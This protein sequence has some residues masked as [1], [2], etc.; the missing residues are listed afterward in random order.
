MEIRTIIEKIYD[1]LNHLTF[2]K[3]TVYNIL[4]LLKYDAVTDSDFSLFIK[5]AED[6]ITNISKTQKELYDTAMFDFYYG[7]FDEMLE[8]RLPFMFESSF[9]KFQDIQ[10]KASELT[11]I[12]GKTFFL[13]VRIPDNPKEQGTIYVFDRCSKQLKTHT[14]KVE[15]SYTTAYEQIDDVVEVDEY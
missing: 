6:V 10:D 12:Y 9:T 13:I 2:T 15:H 8:T 7:T 14:Y 1:N 11:R 3:I 5:L 4:P